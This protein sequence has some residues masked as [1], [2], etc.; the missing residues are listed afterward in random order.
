MAAEPVERAEDANPFR[1]V[2]R[3]EAA[4]LLDV[5]PK[6]LDKL[7]KLGVIPEWRP[8]GASRVVRIPW[9]I[10][11]QRI[12]QGFGLEVKLAPQTKLENWQKH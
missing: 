5:S 8:E 3:A 12:S 1:L 4:R 6:E 2:K 11:V 10:V 9:W 7:I